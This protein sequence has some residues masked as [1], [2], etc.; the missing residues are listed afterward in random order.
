MNREM[1][2]DSLILSRNQSRLSKHQ[3]R[4]V[5]HRAAIRA[6]AVVTKIRQNQSAGS[7]PS[8][9]TIP[10]ESPNAGQ[11]VNPYPRE[12]RYSAPHPPPD[13]TPVALPKPPLVEIFDPAVFSHPSLAGDMVKFKLERPLN[14]Q[15]KWITRVE[16]FERLVVSNRL[17]L[18][19][20][21]LSL[22]HALLCSLSLSTLVRVYS[23]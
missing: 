23:T 22:A 10:A 3:R 16:S 21:T 14:V 11:W 12:A 5:G 2:E 18:V 13:A 9:R 17:H 20:S 8:R 1:F 6:A 19:S 4:M 7:T 15:K